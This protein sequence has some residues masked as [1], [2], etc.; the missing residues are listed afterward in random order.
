MKRLLDTAV[1][2]FGRCNGRG[3]WLRH[4]VPYQGQKDPGDGGGWR[5]MSRAEGNAESC[6]P[7]ALPFSFII[8]WV[9]G[10]VIEAFR[11][12]LQT[13]RSKPLNNAEHEIN[14]AD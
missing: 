7:A 1:G 13:C 6:L 8:L 14:F 9:N 11:W 10:E 12:K 5:R 2:G 4:P 3:E